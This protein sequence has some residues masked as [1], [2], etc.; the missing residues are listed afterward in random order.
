MRKKTSRCLNNT[1][2]V[3]ANTS[4]SSTGGDGY[5]MYTRIK[6]KFRSFKFELIIQKINLKTS[7]ILN[8]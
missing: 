2:G 8:I 6:I 3:G 7:N 4:M 1:P 5:E